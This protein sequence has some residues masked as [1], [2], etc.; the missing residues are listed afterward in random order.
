[1][2]VALP[3]IRVTGPFDGVDGL[4]FFTSP[5]GSSYLKRAGTVSSLL[6]TTGGIRAEPARG[7]RYF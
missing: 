2:A 4:T 5:A 3:P 1:M 6:V 7:K